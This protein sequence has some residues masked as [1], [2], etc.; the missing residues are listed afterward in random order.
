MYERI[1]RNCFDTNE[2]CV[3][4]QIKSII[5]DKTGTITHGKP[6][7]TQTKL[8]V[9]SDVCSLNAFLSIVGTAESGSEHSIGMAISRNAKEV[10]ETQALGHCTDFEAVPGYGLKCMV[11]GI[12]SLTNGEPVNIQ[13]VE[14]LSKGTYEVFMT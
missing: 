13:P 2:C 14:G 8:F 9:P 3:I 11:S 1:A 6:V 4:L 7:V 5:F 10:L 12:E